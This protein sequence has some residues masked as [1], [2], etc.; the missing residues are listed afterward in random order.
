M[1]GHAA[2]TSIL[3]DSRCSSGMLA[4]RYEAM[5][6]P[7]ALRDEMTH[8]INFLDVPDHPR[9]RGLVSRAFTPRRIDALRPW[10]DAAAHAAVGSLEPD[11][12]G[13]VELFEGFVHDLPSLVVSELLGV[14]I[15]DRARLTGWSDAVTPVFGTSIVRADLER[16]LAA[17]EE[18]R[19]Y[20]EWLVDER[21]AAPGDDLLSAL[22]AVSSDDEQLSHVELMSLVT[23]LYSAGHR[24]TR[25]LFGNGIDLVLRRGVQLGLA[26]PDMMVG[27]ML[28]LATP[29]HYVARV[30]TDEISLD[31]IE[32][33]AGTPVTIFL[34]AANRDPAT[35]ET[36]ASA[37]PFRGLDELVVRV[38]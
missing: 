20:M 14:P 23:T 17:A 16:A 19:A 18:M 28:R 38:A 4:A 7:G 21:G 24:T 2:A 26:A 5:L 36:L 11:A 31:G 13:T 25:D 6:P 32:I 37:C 1:F 30:P 22:L 8:R 9:V 29:T 35:Y 34:A 33:A 15:A 12:D 10:I 27:E 3:R